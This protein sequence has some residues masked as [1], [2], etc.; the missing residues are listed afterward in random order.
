MLEYALNELLSA[1][2]INYYPSADTQ[3]RK[4]NAVQS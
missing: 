1:I 4:F 3:S 2:I